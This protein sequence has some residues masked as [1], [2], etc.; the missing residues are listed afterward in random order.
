VPAEKI[1]ED[2]VYRAL[3]RMLPHKEAIE[4]RLKARSPLLY[5]EA[6]GLHACGRTLAAAGELFRRAAWSGP[7]GRRARRT[8]VRRR[9]GLGASPQALAQR[10]NHRL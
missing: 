4:Q 7:P 10:L 3:D 2:R 6:T 5:R 1:N 9:R 8:S